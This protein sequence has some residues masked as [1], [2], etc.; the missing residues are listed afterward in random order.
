MLDN[1][2]SRVNTEQGHGNVDTKPKFFI[3]V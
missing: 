1:P 3:Y 2:Y